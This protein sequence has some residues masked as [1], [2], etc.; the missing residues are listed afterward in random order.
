MAL[1]ISKTLELTGLNLP[2]MYARIDTIA[3]SKNGLDFSLN[4]Y[5]SREAFLSGRSF[6]QQERYSFVPSV[7]IGSQN[8]IKQAYLYV[9]KLDAFKDVIDVF[10]EGQA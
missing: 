7:E 2:D 3:G 4:Y 8:F 10:E 6:L 1:K 5:V 9:K